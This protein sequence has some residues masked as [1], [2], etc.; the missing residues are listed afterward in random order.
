MYDEIKKLIID[1]GFVKNGKTSTW[2]ER[3]I[4]C[5]LRNIIEEQTSFL[6][7]ENRLFVRI[8]CIMNDIQEHP[9][10]KHCNNNTKFHASLKNFSECCSTNCATKQAVPKRKQTCLEKYGVETNLLT[11]DLETR[12]EIAKNAQK[13]S[14]ETIKEKYG[15][16]NPMKISGVK[17][18]HQEIV[19]KK[20][21]QE[22]RISTRT[23][24]EKILNYD[25]SVLNEYRKAV[26]H[27]TRHS[28][29]KSLP[30]YDKRGRSGI[31]GAY[32]LDHIISVFEGFT[33]NIP[34]EIIG[35]IDNLRYIPWEENIEKS[36]AFSS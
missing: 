28:G 25:L 23:K 35:S 15:V 27:Y 22:K 32:Q 31:K 13:K 30:N 11:I 3:K 19:S 24:S 12:K 8:F 14:L 10:C 29:Y 9:K 6:K 18:K 1:G 26:G 7:E 17:E 2:V 4:S 21:F 20:E 36:C 16:D 34:P 5:N 33:K